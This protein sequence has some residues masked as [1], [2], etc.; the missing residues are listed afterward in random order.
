[1]K[2]LL[3]LVV[4]TSITAISSVYAQPIITAPNGGETIAGGSVY[5]IQWTKCAIPS[6]CVSVND[7]IEYSTNNGS[8]W[9]VITA[10]VSD[11]LQFFNWTTPVIAST[12]C[13]V[14][15]TNGTSDVSNAVFTITGPAGIQNKIDNTA[16]VKFHPN[17]AV[18]ELFITNVDTDTKIESVQLY[19]CLG[20]LV[21]N[22]NLTIELSK[23]GKVS[24]ADIT[25]GIYFLGFNNGSPS[26]KVMVAH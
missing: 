13:L 21:K 22:E 11:A 16:S 12:Q 8:S 7:M 15:I 19:N 23:E 1:M 6:F 24:V 14:K 5:K 2:K 3:Q 17:P 25:N 20:A 4:F 26:R 9:T 10:S 18:S